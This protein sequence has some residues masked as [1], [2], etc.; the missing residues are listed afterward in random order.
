MTP[1]WLPLPTALPDRE[2]ELAVLAARL[3]EGGTVGIVGPPGV[4]KTT[5]AGAAARASGRPVF[6]VSLLGCRDADDAQRALGAAVGVR[7]CADEVATH[8]ALRARGPVLLVVDDVAQGEVLAPIERAVGAVPG[9]VAVVI[10][11]VAFGPDPVEVGEPGGQPVGTALRARLAYA[12]GVPPDEVVAS[13]GATARWL[14]AWPVGVAPGVVPALPAALLR[15]DLHD[16]VVLRRGVAALVDPEPEPSTESARR[17]LA[18]VLE[19]ARGAH[20]GRAPDPRDVLLLRDLAER[21]PDPAAVPELTAARARLLI[22]LGHPEVARRLLDDPPPEAGF[23]GRALVAQA[24]VE[25]AFHLG[26]LDGAW[27]Q[28][29]VAAEAY[30]AAGEPAGERK[31][32]V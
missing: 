12:L 19:L 3:S 23:A 2:A 13:L 15:P 10:S 32:V 20:V 6:G 28:A 7:P 30:G 26:E 29:L 8:A 17:S 31:S 5:L 16:R 21:T 1:P 25:L 14:A 22:V 9:A 24:R 27:A 11:E 4:G 18:G